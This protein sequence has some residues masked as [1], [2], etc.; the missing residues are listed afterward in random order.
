MHQRKLLD[1]SIIFRVI[2]KR[3]VGGLSWGDLCWQPQHH[4]LI[5]DQKTQNGSQRLFSV[6]SWFG[7]LGGQKPHPRSDI[8]ARLNEPR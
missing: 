6:L 5:L 2:C 4:T 7:V 3:M 8:L 1:S